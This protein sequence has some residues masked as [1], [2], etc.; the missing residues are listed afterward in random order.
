MQFYDRSRFTLKA[1]NDRE[2]YYYLRSNI[3]RLRRLSPG[4]MDV[5]WY[6][7][8]LGLDKYSI[9]VTQRNYHYGRCYSIGVVRPNHRLP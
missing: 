4:H 7:A 2:H 6:E 5:L 3:R 9:Q 1:C 8:A